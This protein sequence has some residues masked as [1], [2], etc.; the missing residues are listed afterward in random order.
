MSRFQGFSADRTSFDLAGDVHYEDEHLLDRFTGARVHVLWVHDRPCPFLI[1]NEQ[2][3][4]LY[5]RPVAASELSSVLLFRKEGQVA[6]L[7]PEDPF[8][9]PTGDS[10]A[11]RGAFVLRDGEEGAVVLFGFGL[12]SSLRRHPAVRFF[13]ERCTS[14]AN[15]LEWI[16]TSKIRSHD[17]PIA[18]SAG[19]S[20]S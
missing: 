17:C 9:G 20:L 14:S 6:G 18:V 3:C 2:V 11:G 10:A 12:S 7:L 1:G 13:L 4:D 16:Q 19:T 8:K 5:R 15:G